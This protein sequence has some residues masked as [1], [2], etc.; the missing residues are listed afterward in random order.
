MLNFD[1]I[2]GL[3]AADVV[4]RSSPGLADYRRALF[5]QRMGAYDSLSYRQASLVS[6]R[7]MTFFSISAS[8]RNSCWLSGE[9]VSLEI[10]DGLDRGIGYSPTF[11]GQVDFPSSRIQWLFVTRDQAAGCLTWDD[12]VNRGGIIVDQASR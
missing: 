10:S 11:L 8:I 2:D 6:H 12:T 3:S 4:F 9:Y 7:R 5:L 1:P